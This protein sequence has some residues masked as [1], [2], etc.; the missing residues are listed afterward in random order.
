MRTLIASYI[1]CI[2]KYAMFRGRSARAEY[3]TFTLVNAIVLNGLFYFGINTMVFGLVTMIPAI[4]VTTRRLHDLN[5]SGWL[6]AVP[7]GI[8]LLA[9]IGFIAMPSSYSTLCW[10]VFWV[11]WGVMIL[12][13]IWLC[14]FRGTPK[15]NHYGDIL[16]K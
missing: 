11:G 10:G 8:I 9:I 7:W 12:M 14:F 5:H 16:L 4:S 13:N 2:R 15:S 6:S 3:V 1:A